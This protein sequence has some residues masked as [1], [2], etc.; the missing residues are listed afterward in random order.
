MS[1]LET[2]PALVVLS[3]FFH[4]DVAPEYNMGAVWEQWIAS[5]DWIV[6]ESP[7]GI[8]K[9]F[10]HMS[11][12]KPYELFRDY[13]RKKEINNRI[14]DIIKN[15]ERVG[16]LSDAGHACI[17][18]PGAQWIDAA[19]QYGCNVFISPGMCSFIGALALSGFSSQRYE[20]HGYLPFKEKARASYLY[21]LFGSARQG[22]TQIVMET[23][24]RNEAF[25]EEIKNQCPQGIRVCIAENV[26]DG[27]QRIQVGFYPFDSLTVNK[28]PT[29]FLFST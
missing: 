1:H 2:K 29:T 26:M 13:N 28:E 4:S 16:I 5:C 23:P 12:R 10:S 3:N 25:L 27:R 19:R 24:Y 7:K 18:D 22:I 17:A 11:V 6:A 9:I 15:N 8:G 14:E 21:R 20:F